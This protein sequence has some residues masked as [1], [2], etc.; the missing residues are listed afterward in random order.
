M[1]FSPEITAVE[2]SSEI[3]LTLQILGLSPQKHFEKFIYPS[4]KEIPLSSYYLILPFLF[5]C[6]PTV[7][8]GVW[9]CTVAQSGGQGECHQICYQQDR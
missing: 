3:I 9:S 6:L 2:S 5:M 7:T 1:F 8:P 4:E